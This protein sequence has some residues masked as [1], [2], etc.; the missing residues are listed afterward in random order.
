MKDIHSQTDHSYISVR[1]NSSFLDW[2]TQPKSFKT[3]P[4]F[5]QRFKIAQYEQLDYLNLVGGITFEKEYPE[6]KYSLR[7]NPSAGGLYP[8][9]VYLQIRSVKGLVSGIYHYEPHTATLCLLQEIDADGV[10]YYSAKKQKQKGIT[11]LISSVYFRSSWKYKNRAIRYILLDAGHQLAAIYAANCV[12]EKNISVFFDFNKLQLND[13][14]GFRDDEMILCGV[15][16]GEKLEKIVDPLR[17][18]LP[19]VSGCDF[20]ESNEFIESSYRDC[21]EYESDD[22]SE[23]SFLQDIPSE[24]LKQTI[25]R[26]RSIRAFRESE[27]TS[28]EFQFLVKGIFDFAKL[29]RVDIFYTIHKVTDT[30]QGLYKNGT[31]ITDGNFSKKSRYLSL[32]Q[33]LGGQSAVTFYFTSQEQV[34]YQKVNILSGFI[35]HIIYLRSEYKQ[36]GCSGLGAYYDEETKKF[37]GTSNNI[38]YLLAV[39]R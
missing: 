37:L 9:E 22:I 34:A 3:Y 36:I 15:S 10:E 7:T 24:D 17:Q 5:F 28:S 1:K 38:L 30:T 26:R 25:L 8:C 19:Y 31:L 32:E 16:T 13:V 23:I 20:L 29:H 21:C 18:N 39:G 2:R 6:G 33:N 14:F 27:I 11:Y 35:A 12:V 4:H